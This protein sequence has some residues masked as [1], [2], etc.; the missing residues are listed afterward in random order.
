[1]S[2]RVEIQSR[3]PVDAGSL[4]F[5]TGKIGEL[6]TLKCVPVCGGDSYQDEMVGSFRLSPMH[7]FLTLDATIEVFSF[8]VPHRHVYNTTPSG[9]KPWENQWVDFINQGPSTI[10]TPNVLTGTV[11][12]SGRLRNALAISS[13]LK[14]SE[15]DTNTTIA[16]WRYQGYWNIFE[17]YFKRPDYETSQ[18]SLATPAACCHLKNMWTAPLRPSLGFSGAYEDSYSNTY[19]SAEDDAEGVSKINMF[20]FNAQDARLH[21]EQINEHWTI[22]FRD[23]IDRLGGSTTAD[24]DQRPTLIA[25]TKEFSSGYDVDGTASDT[26]GQ[27]VG[28]CVTGF[29]HKVPRF[30]CGEHGAI[31]T[32]AVVRFPPI[33]ANENHYL[34]S[35]EPSYEELVNDPD[36]VA[37]LP[38]VNIDSNDLFYGNGDANASGGFDIAMPYGQWY[39]EHPSYVSN[40][41]AG[42]EGFPFMLYPQN[43]E[44]SFKITPSDYDLIFQGTQYQH[45]QWFGRS[46]A[47]ILREIASIRTALMANP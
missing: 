17:N 42:E 40:H 36:L 20:E 41:F 10:D 34:E 2:E 7:R 47:M 16:K 6:T 15:I 24:T 28:R 27:Y 31:W 14:D 1:M 35:H 19:F 23:K 44:A 9:N 18:V 8:Y 3:K 30:Y 25:H 4:I 33:C 22:R 12:V 26:L 43:F 37:N 46:N 13:D 29:S 45:W 32:V 38:P 21:I 11:T 39:R 5:Q